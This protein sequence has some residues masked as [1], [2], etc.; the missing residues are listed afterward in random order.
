MNIGLEMGWRHLLF[1]NWPADPATVAAHLPDALTIDTHDG[2]AW[3]SV[4]PFRN[5]NLRPRGTPSP[6]GFDLPEPNLRTYVTHEGNS[7][8]YF[9]SLDAAGIFGVLGARLLHHL[10]YYY[11][12]I[13][14]RA[15]DDSV[16]FRSRRSHPG[17]RPARFAATYE[18]AGE[19]I[20]ADARAAFLTERYRFYT[21]AP[22]GTVRHTDVDHDKWTLYPTEMKIA[23]NT[24]FRAN[25]FTVPKSDP[26]C[27]YSPGVDVVASPSQSMAWS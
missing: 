21:E 16:R 23:E 13:Q 11:A 26:V 22:D 5:V 9:F 8:V 2:T 6:I 14:L 24:L 15:T 1:A 18:P 3:L 12:N 27:Y 20:A 25:G 19:Q 10:P 4:V 7:G 17:A